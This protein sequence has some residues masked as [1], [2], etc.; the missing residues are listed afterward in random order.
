MA[1]KDIDQNTADQKDVE[2]EK[3]AQEND[4][5]N[6]IKQRLKIL[7][8]YKILFEQTD[9]N[10]SITMPQIIEELDKYGIKAAR[11][12]LYADIE[13]LREF[14]ADIVLDRCGNAGYSLVSRDFEI[15]ELVILADAVTCSR[16]FT[17][18]KA[19]D[20][21]QKLEKLCSCYEARKIDNSVFVLEGD[22]LDN[23]RIYINVD[24]IHQA[25]FEEKQISFKYFNYDLKKHKKYRNGSL[26]C[27]PYALTWSDEKYYLIAHYPKYNTISH[28]RV[29]KMES[30]RIL[31]DPAEPLPKR[32]KL[33][34]YLESTFSMFS[35]T[36]ETV[37]LRFKN[38]LAGAI[39]DRFGRKVRI[40]RDDEE[41]FTI[42]FPVR[43]EHPETF[44]G[45]VFQFGDEAE[46]L[47]PSDLRKR[48]IST[49]K[50]SLKKANENN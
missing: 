33:S 13:A 27:S 47:E 34:G 1:K 10:H 17:Q 49:L 45:W 41:H 37:K 8:L 19:K 14:G 38:H 31:S 9:E 23:E 36:A 7:Y 28:F 4:D 5:K 39:I 44:F 35:G 3:A 32:F 11:K 18:K 50:A 6:N 21:V 26:V 29:D 15:A 20:L 2:Q 12:A 48:Y 16:F 25:I 40:T 24:T 42:E 46:I 22:K 43:T 30:V